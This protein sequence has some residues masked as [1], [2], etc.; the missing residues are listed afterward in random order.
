VFVGLPLAI[1]H[2]VERGAFAGWLKRLTTRTALMHL[3]R[4]ESRKTDSLDADASTHHLVQPDSVLER[5]DLESAIA[6]LPE[7]LRVVFVLSRVEQLSHNEIAGVLGIRRGTSEVRLHRAIRRL[8]H[9]LEEK[10]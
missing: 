4:R 2:Y 7:P 1:G 5:I 8:R 9:L 6:S 3:R 10:P